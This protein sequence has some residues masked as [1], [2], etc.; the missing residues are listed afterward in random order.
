[1]FMGSYHR[2]IR[3]SHATTIEQAGSGHCLD[4]INGTTV[5]FGYRHCQAS[6]IRHAC[7]TGCVY[8][9]RVWYLTGTARSLSAIEKK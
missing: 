8:S 7:R 2:A 1:M 3:Q 4:A 9:L 6:W 5:C